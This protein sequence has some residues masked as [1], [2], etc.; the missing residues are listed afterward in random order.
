[1]KNILRHTLK[2][3][4]A[5]TTNIGCRNQCSYCPQRS[6]VKAY[7]ER[8]DINQMPIDT[9]VRCIHS[10][11]R[12]TCISFSGFSEPWLNPDCTSMVLHSHKKGF[13]I[14]VNTTLVGMST[15]D[16]QILK[17]VPFIKFVIHLPDNQNRTRI[18]VDQSYLEKVLLLTK[19]PVS[20]LCWK[21][22]Q[23]SPDIEIHPE[24]SSVLND[25]RVKINFTSLNNRA[26]NINTGIVYP[27][28]NQGRVLENCQDFR[29]NILLPNGDVVLCHMDWS[30]Q[31]ILGNLLKQDYASLYRGEEMI[32]IK[33]GLHN[34]GLEILCRHCEKDIVKRTPGE[35]ILH[36][37]TKIIKGGRSPY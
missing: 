12:E 27:L 1:M 18:K 15:Q 8:S 19:N 9:F 36:S 13:A 31:H 29:H 17:S 35:L 21:F 24:V 5:I 6:F 25:K 23:T 30:L 20:N 37:L 3:S 32:K 22:H 26:G 4:L 10:L 7:K 2:S 14:R 16:L 33:K 34:P 11:P 28:P